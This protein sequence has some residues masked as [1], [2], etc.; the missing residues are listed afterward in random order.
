VD[1]DYPDEVPEV[2]AQ[3]PRS[4]VEFSDPDN[5]E[6]IIRADLTWLTSRWQCIFGNGCPGVYAERPHDGCCTLG[7]HFSDADDRKRVKRWA[8]RLDADTW[9]RHPEGR[10]NGI[11]ERD[12]EGAEKT[13]VV[14]GAC[15]F[16]NDPDFPGGAGCALHHLAA[17]EGVS[18]VATKPDV[19]WQLPLRREYDWREERDGTRKLVITL[20]EYTRA[21]WGEGGH[22]FAWYCSANTEAHTAA[23]PVYRSA[24]AEITELIGEP[25]AAELIV[26][27][28]AHEESQRERAARHLPLLTVHPATAA[29][30]PP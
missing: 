19:C 21:G 29:A 3:F 5:D 13:R 22:D 26:H 20:T 30:P 1:G 4:W 10:R 16:L 8:K 7:A 11:V 6:Q 24:V 2:A 15:I 12:E 9:Q 28:E 25:A 18:F 23:E 17:R 14:D 27:C